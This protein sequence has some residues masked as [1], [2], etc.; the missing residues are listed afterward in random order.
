MGISL[1]QQPA[2]EVL[3]QGPFRIFQFSNRSKRV[4]GSLE[5]LQVGSQEES[6]VPETT[7][8]KL[9]LGEETFDM[10]GRFPDL[11]SAMQSEPGPPTDDSASASSQ[12]QQSSSVRKGRS[13]GGRAPPRRQTSGTFQDAE[14]ETELGGDGSCHDCYGLQ[15]M[16][17]DSAAGFPPLKRKPGSVDCRAVGQRPRVRKRLVRLVPRQQQQIV[18][19]PFSRLQVRLLR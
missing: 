5:C 1:S 7:G 6:A 17:G 19:F 10:G 12:Q 14:D 11:G 2:Q 15:P 4:D 16:S 9:E 18:A 8:D 13:R 3:S